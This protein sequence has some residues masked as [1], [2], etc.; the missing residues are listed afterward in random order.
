MRKKSRSKL[1]LLLYQST[2]RDEIS[3]SSV[4]S[5]AITNNL[6]QKASGIIDDIFTNSDDKMNIGINYL[7]GDKNAASSLLNRDRLGLTL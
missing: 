6:F 4:S 2:F 1:F 7:K 3:L 5:Q